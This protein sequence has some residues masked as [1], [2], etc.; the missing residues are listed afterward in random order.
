MTYAREGP[1]PLHLPADA[2]TFEDFL[3][4]RRLHSLV[5]MEIASPMTHPCQLPPADVPAAELTEWLDWQGRCTHPTAHLALTPSAQACTR[6]VR[7]HTCATEAVQL[8]S[9]LSAMSHWNALVSRVFSRRPKRGARLHRPGADGP[10]GRVPRRMH[11]DQPAR[12]LRVRLHEECGCAGLCDSGSTT[13]DRALPPR[14]TSASQSCVALSSATC[15]GHH[16]TIRRYCWS[17][18]RHCRPTGSLGCSCTALHRA[19]LLAD[20]TLRKECVRQRPN[21]PLAAAGLDWTGL[22]WTGLD[23]TGLDSH[24]ANR[25]VCASAALVLYCYCHSACAQ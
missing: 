18:Y 21:P 22:D 5:S 16:A 3:K 19:E 11:T 7:M 1:G 12:P 10:A 20:E 13:R 15:S 23:W 2:R 4:E 17:M 25:H 14:P 8:G 24:S 6:N 9:P